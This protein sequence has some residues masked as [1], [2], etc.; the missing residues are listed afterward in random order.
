[1]DDA[2]RTA[3]LLLVATSILVFAL[4]CLLLAFVLSA[5]EGV[6]N[7]ALQGTST[8]GFV[9]HRRRQANLQSETTMVLQTGH[10]IAWH[11][12]LLFEDQRAW[13]LPA[14]V[15]GKSSV[16]GTDE[17][18]A[19][20]AVELGFLLARCLHEYGFV[21]M[22]LA[23]QQTLFP[24]YEFLRIVGVQLL[25]NAVQNDH[26]E[27][28][29]EYES[30]SLTY[31]LDVPLRHTLPDIDF[32]TCCLCVPI[33]EWR[34]PFP[35]WPDEDVD[36]LKEYRERYLAS[37]PPP[38]NAQLYYCSQ[39]DLEEPQ[40]SRSV[41]RD[42][43]QLPPTKRLNGVELWCYARRLARAH[44]DDPNHFEY[45]LNEHDLRELAKEPMF[46]QEAP[47]HPSGCSNDAVD[48]TVVDEA[49]CW[50]ERALEPKVPRSRANFYQDLL[51]IEPDRQSPLAS[52]SRG[53][54]LYT[55]LWMPKP[56]YV[57]SSCE[58]VLSDQSLRELFQ[59]V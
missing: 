39:N 50:W 59:Y 20:S 2:P 13:A 9:K 5:K 44:D 27:S 4:L 34:R 29:D 24:V 32:V 40:I 56:I 36:S 17:I 19:L 35:Y 12:Y 14:H 57:S 10:V 37:L 6:C 49:K 26:I 58:R 55:G 42:A 22:K 41:L 52:I 45:G 16:L 11:T 23:F 28:V 54:W 18:R 47:W 7:A 46:F 43:H 31:R 33:T 48:V 15:A 53:P 51:R 3:A 38:K 1:M 25:P 8:K 30:F 21:M